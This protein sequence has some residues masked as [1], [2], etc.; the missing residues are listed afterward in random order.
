MPRTKLTLE[1]AGRKWTTQS[2]NLAL[3]L[4]ERIQLI[5]GFS[6]EAEQL[7]TQ[8]NGP[9]AK[10]IRLAFGEIYINP[11]KGMKIKPHSALRY[12]R[13]HWLSPEVVDLIAAH[14]SG[15]S[16]HSTGL[17]YALV[18]AEV[19]NH[20]TQ[21]EL[22][23]SAINE[24]W[25]VR[26][27]KEMAEPHRDI[28]S[29]RKQPRPMVAFGKIESAAVGIHR[30]LTELV[31]ADILLDTIGECPYRSGEEADGLVDKIVNTRAL[32]DDVWRMRQ[33]VSDRLDLAVARVL[34]SGR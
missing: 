28:P 2:A 20:A 21:L 24:R 8:P 15:D 5:Y 11:A 12:M 31:M 4:G 16:G 17:S 9:S 30:E 14:A 22:L 1:T 26:K 7:R 10:E 32:L 23:K 19:G 13:F 6:M 18:L 25:R 34:E 27:L 29:I 3:L 33:K